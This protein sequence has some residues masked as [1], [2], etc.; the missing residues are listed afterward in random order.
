M[1]IQVHPGTKV[2]V[3]AVYT[4]TDA[5][6]GQPGPGKFVAG[7]DKWSSSNT[8][9]ALNNQQS[10]PGNGKTQ[11]GVDG[12][13][14]VGTKS[15]IHV[16]ADVDEGPADKELGGDSEEL[17]W[18]TDVAILADGLTVGVVLA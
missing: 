12:T 18:T 11:T 17:E 15:I 6:T 9:D 3:A 14:S 5:A 8:L 13:A 2:T 4:L 10:D 7:T 1:T 16:T